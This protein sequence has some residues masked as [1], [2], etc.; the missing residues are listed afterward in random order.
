[1]KYA[2]FWG[3]PKFAFLTIVLWS[4]PVQIMK[5]PKKEE[6]GSKMRRYKILI[7]INYHHMQPCA[8][9]I[10]KIIKKLTN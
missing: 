10:M 9:Q 2:H 3:F 8:I 1:M 6:N 7:L 4:L 5:K